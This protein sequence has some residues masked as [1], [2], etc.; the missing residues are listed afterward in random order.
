MTPAETLTAPSERRA[1]ILADASRRLDRLARRVDHDWSTLRYR[2][3]RRP[4]APSPRT[5]PAPRAPSR[6]DAGDPTDAACT[7]KET[8]TMSTSTSREVRAEMFH[9][10]R[11]N[12]SVN[13]N[14]RFVV[15]TTEGDFTISTDSAC[16]YDV[17]N[18]ASRIKVGRPL[19]VVVKLTRA[20]RFF[21]I[22]EDHE[23]PERVPMPEG[24]LDSLSPEDASKARE[25]AAAAR[26]E[27]AR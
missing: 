5:G 24:V 2:L 16:A 3:T 14:P 8:E 10:T 4:H 27:A 6:T 7:G 23:A 21:D 12:N 1:A 20:G 22:S 17:E 15:H 19:P 9:V 18:L 11:L 13:G 25:R 26:R